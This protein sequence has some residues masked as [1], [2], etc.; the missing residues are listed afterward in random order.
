MKWIK[1]QLNNPVNVG[2]DNE[3]V[4]IDNLSDKALS[5]CEANLAIAEKEAHEG[6]YSIDDDGQ[7]ESEP[8]PVAEPTTDDVLNVLLGVM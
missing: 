3:P 8:E 7:P 4:F 1:Y 2:T 5:Y 6:K